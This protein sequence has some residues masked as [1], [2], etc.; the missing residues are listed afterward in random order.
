MTLKEVKI[1]TLQKCFSWNGESSLTDSR[2]EEY[3]A[4][5][6]GAA[7]EALLALWNDHH[8]RQTMPVQLSGPVELA[9]VL[10]EWLPG[11]R[12]RVMADLGGGYPVELTDGGVVNGWLVP[13]ENWPAQV[14]VEYE[15][16]PEIITAETPDSYELRCG[17]E[18]AVLL[19]WHIAGEVYKEDDISIA[20]QY[21]NEFEA[22]RQALQ[23]R[24]GVGAVMTAACPVFDL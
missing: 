7:N 11:S 5:M 3:L 4:A 2:N 21:L 1:A 15:T 10:K 16:R 20:T 23:W 14:L 19:P 24:P 22:A 13:G 18:R 9:A 8:T 17:P 12:P 6:P